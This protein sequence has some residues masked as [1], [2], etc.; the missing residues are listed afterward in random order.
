MKYFFFTLTCIT[1]LLPSL[2]LAQAQVFPTRLTL[3]EEGPSSYL[4][5]KNSTEKPQKYRIEF[6][7]FN[8][9]KDG[10]VAKAGHVNNPLSDVIKFSPKTVEIAPN[11]KQIVRVMA[12]SFDD[13]SDG[14]HLIYL[15]FI[16]ESIEKS[17]KS[18]S[19]FNLQARIA[20]AVPVVVRRGTP[21]LEGKLTD[22]K[23]KLDPKKNLSLSF[24]LAN[25]TKFFLTGDLDIIGVTDQGEVPLS[26]IVGISS[27]IPERSFSTKLSSLEIADK[28][29]DAIKKV[30]VRYAA[31][32]DSATTFDLSAEADLGSVNLGKKKTNKRQ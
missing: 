1:V 6:V 20:I 3:T 24:N 8:M 12:T 5:L 14:E 2:C 28:T 7:Q 21:K 32:A 15:H 4:N 19:N 11:E 23:A 16:P 26:K 10:T 25:K 22:L 13:L 29:K 9:K 27:Y 30:K 17:P 18:N 31:N